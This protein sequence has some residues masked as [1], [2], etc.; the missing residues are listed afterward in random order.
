[1]GRGKLKLGEVGSRGALGSLKIVQLSARVLSV[2]SWAFH[3]QNIHSF[4]NS[5]VP[6][7]LPR[8]F[9]S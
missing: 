3:E 1:M 6:I 7:Y 5:L 8:V 9:A 2:F 4:A